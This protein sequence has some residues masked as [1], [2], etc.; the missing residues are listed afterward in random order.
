MSYG[1]SRPRKFKIKN[2]SK[3]AG[4]VNNIV[5]RSSWEKIFMNYLDTSN[6]VKKWNSE[7]L[8][9]EYISPK[10]NKTHRYFPDFLVEMADGRRM[11]VEIKPRIFY[12]KPKDNNNRMVV[13]NYAI[14]MS[15]FLAAQK[16]AKDNNC[17]FVILNEHDLG[18]KKL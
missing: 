16:L 8:A 7:E 5:F 15:K 4:N 9:I 1:S 3:Y 6:L 13:L 11:I 18:I 17:E 14:N 2:P 12:E 10:D